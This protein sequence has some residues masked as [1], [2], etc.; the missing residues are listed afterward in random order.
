MDEEPSWQKPDISSSLLDI[1]VLPTLLT[2][3]ATT[4]DEKTD[5]QEKCVWSNSL[6][7]S[8]SEV[9]WQKEITSSSLNEINGPSQKDY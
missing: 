6:F 3:A 8:P 5:R 2:W 4:T 1:T 7:V 9:S